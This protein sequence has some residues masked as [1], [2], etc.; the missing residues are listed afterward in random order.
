MPN[1]DNMKKQPRKKKI[2]VGIDFDG[3]IAYNPFRVVRAPISFVKRNIFGIRH[4]KFYVPKTSLEKVMWTVLHESSVFP[5]PG[6]GLLKDLV[7]QD[8]IEAHLVTAR[9]SFLQD[10]LYQWLRR[11]SLESLF[12]SITVNKLDEQP[13]TYKESVIKQRQFDYFIEDN[14]DIVQHLTKTT[15]TQILWIYNLLDRFHPYDKKFPYLKKALEHIA[16]A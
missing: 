8:Q 9:F 1:R 16:N 12:S 14:L 2:V 3:V 4:T 15:D 13:H 5:A 11:Y 6:V 7:E 10:H